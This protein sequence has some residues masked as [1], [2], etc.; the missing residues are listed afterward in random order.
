M[1]TEDADSSEPCG[2]TVC[3]TCNEQFDSESAVKIHHSKT[4]G[5]SIA[6]VEVEC[7]NCGGTF[8]K[9]RSHAE[10]TDHNFCDQECIGQWKETHSTGENNPNWDGGKVTVECNNCG[11]E[12]SRKRNKAESSEKHFCDI[13]CQAEWR[14][15]NLTGENHWSYDSAEVSCSLCGKT[16]ERP[17][18][19]LE[20]QDRHFC[21]G[22]CWGTWLSR[23]RSGENAPAW[24]GGEVETI[25]HNCGSVITRKRSH[26]EAASRVFCDYGCAAAWKE[27]YYTGE[28]NPNWDG[29]LVSIECDQCGEVVKRKPN[30]VK[31]SEYSFC[32]RDC[33][34][35]WREENLTGEDH[36]RWAGGYTAY[37]G[38]S[39][40][41]QRRKALVRDNHQ[42]QICGIDG[43]E[44]LEVFGE[45]LH[46]HHVIRFRS[47]HDAPGEWHNH[48]EANSL[49]NLLTLCQTH[50]HEWEG[51]SLRPA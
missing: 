28:N 17:R 37:Y 26:V 10:K 8:R 24:D 1:S 48:E 42:C 11:T 33:H 25:C 46:M 45:D 22:D 39:Y 3:P 23:H 20:S 38:P 43:Q 34:G 15:E 51:L 4:H 13:S 27:E 35:R 16:I 36:Y 41:E 32:S 29:G 49:D 19:K 30:Q 2:S 40:P 6:G 21:S 7:D 9:K 18:S 31:R 44:H 12:L 50:H 47:F 14:S 5:E